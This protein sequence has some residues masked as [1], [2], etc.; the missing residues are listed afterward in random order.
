MTT[1]WAIYLRF[2]LTTKLPRRTI[3]TE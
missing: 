1:D 3:L 2:E